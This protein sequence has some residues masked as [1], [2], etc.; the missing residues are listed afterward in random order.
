MSK[1]GTS[2]E[3]LASLCTDVS[4]LKD[5]FKNHLAH[6]WAFTMVLLAAIL[7]EAAGFLILVIKHVF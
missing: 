4:W 6:H 3:K 5:Q 2:K 1:Q 7:G